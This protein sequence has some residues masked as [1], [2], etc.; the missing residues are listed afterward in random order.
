[1]PHCLLCRSASAITSA[2]TSFFIFVP[3]CRS[4]GL[5]QRGDVG[6]V[7]EVSGV[8]A[9]LVDA[10]DGKVAAITEIDCLILQKQR[11]CFG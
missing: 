4:R 10:E 7:M 8:K 11:K 5:P 3:S 9:S 6:R 2:S 1:M